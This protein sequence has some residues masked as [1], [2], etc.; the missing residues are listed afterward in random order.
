MAAFVLFSC[1][2]ISFSGT[3]NDLARHLRDGELI[4]GGEASQILHRNYYSYAH[5]EAVFI[6][7]HWLMSVIFYLIY[8]AA[9]LE[10]LNAFYIALGAVT[11]ALYFWVAE[12]EAG[13]P[14]AAAVSALLMPLLALRAGVRPEVF[15]LLLLGVFFAI[16][17]GNYRGY[18]GQ[19]WLWLLP[20]L[21]IFWVNLHPGFILGPTLVGAFLAAEL[22]SWRAGKRSTR[23][24]HS[25]NW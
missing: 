3:A 22:F 24:W 12:R 8:K 21:E 13:L 2:H 20:V 25:L 14:G 6:N 23:L 4:L 19:A 10:G 17:W 9:G 11:F 18:M 16:L 15:S 1:Q 7:H 5:P